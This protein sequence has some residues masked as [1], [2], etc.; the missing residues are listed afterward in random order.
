MSWQLF[1]S[2]GL[3]RGKWKWSAWHGRCAG[4]PP[5]RMCSSASVSPNLSG[6]AATV[7]RS[8]SPSRDRNASRKLRPRSFSLSGARSPSSACSERR[9]PMFVVYCTDRLSP[10]GGKGRREVHHQAAAA[11]VQPL[12]RQVTK[13][14]EGHR[15]LQD[16]AFCAQPL[17]DHNIIVRSS[18]CRFSEHLGVLQLGGGGAELALQQRHDGRHILQVPAHWR[19][20]DVILQV[21][22]RIDDATPQGVAVL[23]WLSALSPMADANSVAAALRNAHRRCSSCS[24]KRRSWLTPMRVRSPL[25]SGRPTLVCRWVTSHSLSMVALDIHDP[26]A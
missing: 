24:R 11:L 17:R 26:P 2:T 8:S 19:K 25:S 21:G 6:G 14:C 3:R 22:R 16:L 15:P 1:W 12:Q 10:A 7:P 5:P 23:R 13:T 9:L 20:N 18:L 4:A